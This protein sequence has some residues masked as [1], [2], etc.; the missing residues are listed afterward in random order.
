MGMFWGLWFGF[1][2]GFTDIGGMQHTVVNRPLCPTFVHD[3]GT[4]VCVC[5]VGLVVCIYVLWRVMRYYGF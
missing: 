3:E 2:S 5:S 1:I 4:R